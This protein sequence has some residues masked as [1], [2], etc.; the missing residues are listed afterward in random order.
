[1]PATIQI[2]VEAQGAL[3]LLGRVR[4][5]AG[6]RLAVHRAAT[7]RVARLDVRP[8]FLD[9]N[10]RSQRSNYWAK[11]AEAVSAEADEAGGAVVIRHPGVGWHRHGGTIQAKDGGAMALPLRG[12]QA[13]V[14][15]SEFFPAHG[16]PDSDVFVWRKGDRA[17]LAARVGKAL[18][19]FYLLLKSVTKPEDASVFPPIERMSA[20]AADAV[21]DLIRQEL[22]RR[23]QSRT[24]PP[25]GPAPVPTA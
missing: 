18:R 21:R 3:A 14:W 15:P 2:V 19:I 8:W 25:G 24:A 20:T 6:A 9:R 5:L 22:S 12:A 17:F 1:M 7:E 16:I 4:G 11:A 10:E 13:G 23:L